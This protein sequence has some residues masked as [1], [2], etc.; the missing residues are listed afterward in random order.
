MFGN[1][2][3]V[4]SGSHKNMIVLND[5]GFYILSVTDTNRGF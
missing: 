1:F 5:F 2:K 3:T 4:I